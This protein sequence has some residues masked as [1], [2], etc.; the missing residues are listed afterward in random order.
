MLNT[1]HESNLIIN[2]LFFGIQEIILMGWKP[3]E[4]KTVFISPLMFPFL[5]KFLGSH[6]S[7]SQKWL[8]EM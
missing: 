3:I 2:L 5:I 8:N 6:L 4:E 7:R 1:T